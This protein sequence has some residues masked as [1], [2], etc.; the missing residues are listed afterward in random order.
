MP[1]RQINEIKEEASEQGRD[2]KTRV[3]LAALFALWLITFM[4][5]LGVAWNAYFKQKEDTLTLAQQIQMA[6]ENGEFDSDF[7]IEDRK[8][9]C[10]NAEKVIEENDPELQDSEIQEEERQEPE[11]QEPEIQEPENQNGER[12]EPE[13]QED[14]AQDDEIQEGE[15]QDPEIQDEEVQEGEEQ[16][17]ENQDE[18]VQDPEVDDPDPAS[19]YTFTF[20]FTVPGPG[21]TP[22]NTY[23]VVCNSGTGECTV[24]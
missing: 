6:C 21:D 23:T 9:L 18:E 8:A 13:S 7:S 22:G 16:E 3:L 11:Y 24:S 1:D 2:P 19:P 10:D 15:R 4:A 12:Q 5:L 14:E 20:T 17:P